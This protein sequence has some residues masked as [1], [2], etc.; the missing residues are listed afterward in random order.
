[1]FN[2][3]IKSFN[4]AVC[5]YILAPFAIIIPA[6]L[7][8]LQ[9]L[10]EILLGMFQS[11]DNF[12]AA[13][14]HH[15]RLLFGFVKIIGIVFFSLIVVPRVALHGKFQ[16]NDIESDK[17]AVTY[18]FKL[19]SI[20]ILICALCMGI[21]LVLDWLKITAELST[22]IK[23]LISILP[24]AALAFLTEKN[25]LYFYSVILSY[26]KSDEV[27]RSIKD[28]RFFSMHSIFLILPA[29]IVLLYIHLLM[30]KIA[31]GLPALPQSIILTLDCTVIGL[32][33]LYIG[34]S[35]VVSF[36]ITLKNHNSVL[37]GRLNNLSIGRN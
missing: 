28:Y 20:L 15:I 34:S 37:Y 14:F 16:S 26:E 13:Q 2:D 8:L 19:I 9:H 18:F 17:K 12:K 21:F 25:A 4:V 32:I 24:I 31:I 1:M 29:Y 36:T 23:L 5:L 10:V 7:E 11:I 6:G 35:T 27:N 30:N 33:A 3:I 22:E